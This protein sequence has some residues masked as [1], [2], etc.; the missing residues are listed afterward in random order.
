MAG[1]NRRRR[2]RLGVAVITYACNPG[3]AGMADASAVSENALAWTPQW[4]PR[5]QALRA[6]NTHL[7]NAHHPHPLATHNSSQPGRT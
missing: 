5:Q 1:F 7:V 2:N 4:Y 6:A 3:Y